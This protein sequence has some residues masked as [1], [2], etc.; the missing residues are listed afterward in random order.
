MLNMNR[1]QIKGNLHKNKQKVSVDHSVI[2]EVVISRSSGSVVTL[3]VK[4]NG[5]ELCSVS[6]DGIILASSNGSTA[7][8]LSANG[9]IVHP[10]VN[11]ILMTPI[12]PFN[13][14]AR[15]LILP[16][17][18]L[19]EVSLVVNSRSKG[20]VNFD[21]NTEYDMEFGDSIQIS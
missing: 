21:G 17:H 19:I 8:S 18:S 16:S 7:Y 4:V 1:L 6:A 15:P 10:D 13:L 5:K 14:N 11:G 12:C 9:S 20:N 2:N 3:E